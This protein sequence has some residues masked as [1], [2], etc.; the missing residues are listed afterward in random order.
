MA[1]LINI[2]PHVLIID[3]MVERIEMHMVWE[4]A[5]HFHLK[6]LS[7]YLLDAKLKRQK[8]AVYAQPETQHGFP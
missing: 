7:K 1:K 8:F 6:S 2:V 5:R 3:L 4:Q